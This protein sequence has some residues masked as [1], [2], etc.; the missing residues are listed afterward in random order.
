MEEFH[1]VLNSRCFKKDK[2]SGSKDIKRQTANNV[3]NF[4]PETGQKSCFQ[5]KEISLQ[6]LADLLYSFNNSSKLGLL[7]FQRKCMS[8]LS[9]GSEI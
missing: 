5:T 2:R 9:S 7:H 4:L 8:A 6:I 3:H 1:F